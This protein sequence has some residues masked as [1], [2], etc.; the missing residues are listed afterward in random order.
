MNS[1]LT[2]ALRRILELGT[3]AA[4]RPDEATYGHLIGLAWRDFQARR[5]TLLISRAA[6]RHLN[7]ASLRYVLDGHL[8]DR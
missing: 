7:T 8:E 1:I 5:Q 4:S 6:V 3:S 2:R